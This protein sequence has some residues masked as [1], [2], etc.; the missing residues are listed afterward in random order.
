MGNRIDKGEFQRPRFI[1]SKV[2]RKLKVFF[3]LNKDRIGKLNLVLPSKDCQKENTVL[4]VSHAEKRCGIHEYGL[5]IAKALSFSSRYAFAYAECSN[6]EELEKVVE[7]SNPSVIIYNYYHLTMPWLTP[8]V[9]SEYE[10]I[11]LG[12]MHEV[13]QEQADSADQTLFDYHLCPDPTLIDS[14]PLIFKTKRLIPEYVNSAKLPKV[15]TIGSFG[16]GFA[17]KGFER[18]IETVQDEFEQAKININ[19][20]FNDIVDKDGKIY[21]LKTAQRCRAIVR[22]PGIKLSITHHFWEK[23]RLLDFLAGN[24][25]NVFF[26]E[27]HKD[28]GLSSCIEHAL[29]VQRPL[30][31]TRSGMFRHVLGAKPSICIEDT[32]L[33]KIIENGVT[34]LLPFYKEWSE[35]SFRLDYESI[36]DKVLGKNGRAVCLDAQAEENRIDNVLNV[37]SFN[38][39]LD[40]SARAQYRR[41]VEDMFRL[42]PEMMSRKIQEANIQQGFIFDT[43]RCFSSHYEKPKILCVGSFEDTAAASLKKIGY[44]IEEIDP[45]LNYDLDEFFRKG[46]TLKGSYDI[47]FSTSVLEHVEN[48]E[49]FLVQ[50]SELLAP[51]GVAILTLD[52]NDQYVP[53]DLIPDVDCRFY[54]QQDLKNRLLPLLKNC[55]LVDEPKWD[56]VNPDFVY[57]GRYRYTFASLVFRKLEI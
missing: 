37:G 51:G 23:E 1:L 10:A 55:E 11:Q 22:K 33:T 2:K 28:R 21:A 30:A 9:T 41:A 50:I 54:T 20:P 36:L 14:N 40:D 25:V 26:Y 7:Q 49:L 18:L 8:Q 12:I 27:T 6:A 32:S 35:A 31:I 42:V 29:A 17:D 24:T 46:A 5:N 4:I 47:V 45:V 15:T 16:F 13:T 39:I 43:V 38:R 44:S 57:A 48:D 34:P 19:M 3:S 53:G 52:Y 56:C